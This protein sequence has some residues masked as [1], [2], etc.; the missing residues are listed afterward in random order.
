MI[1][2][3]MIMNRNVGED[4]YILIAVLVTLLLL[5]VIGIGSLT[6]TT[7]E[8]QIA[9]NDL[10]A[11]KAFYAADGAAQ[12]GAAFLEQLLDDDCAN[13]DH[14][15]SGQPLY[16]QS[17]YENAAGESV[18]ALVLEEDASGNK[19]MS[20]DPLFDIG[21]G[22]QLGEA[23]FNLSVETN[24]FN[25]DGSPRYTNVR[26]VRLTSTATLPNS[27]TAQVEL[28][29]SMQGDP[30]TYSQEHYDTENSGR[31]STSVDIS[32]QRRVIDES[33]HTYK[34]TTR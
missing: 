1:C 25:P 33:G 12:A 32:N 21:Q 26:S 10:T 6:T 13:W 28:I 8:L 34:S 2:K 20:L 3:V 14:L 24:T 22:R 17:K 18:T 23:T 4:G 27:S 16:P 5:I 11:R 31:V 7:T 19:R 30:C 15:L 9:G 29:V